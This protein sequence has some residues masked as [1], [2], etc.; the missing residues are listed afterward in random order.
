METK[1]IKDIDEETWKEFKSLAAKN[2]L[3]MAALLK[4][5]IKNFEKNNK[6]FWENILNNEKVL[7]DREADDMEKIINNNRKEEGFRNDISI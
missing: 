6:D 4:I 2:N 7:S 5:L 3:K 1:C